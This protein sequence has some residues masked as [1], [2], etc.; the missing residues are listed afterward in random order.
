MEITG[1]PQWD[2]NLF[3]KIHG[4]WTAP[5]LDTI[6]PIWR[7]KRT[8]VPLYAI[9]LFLLVRVF[10][11]QG[12]LLGV[13]AGCCVGLA[14]TLSSSVIKPAVARLRPCRTEELSPFIRDIIDCGPGL[15]FPSSHA[16]NHF[17]LAVFL[18]VLFHRRYA[19][20]SWVGILWAF[21]IAYAQVYVGLHFPL[22]IMG[23]AALGSIIG[24]LFSRVFL[25]LKPD[26]SQKLML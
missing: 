15:S 16:A 26:W 21:S 3:V 7:D 8:W 17:A 11:W 24:V 22:D 4:H 10:R 18:F 6:L 25:L 13:M 5:W 14:D 9:L 12:V 1:W 2:F 19:L 20:A 23:G